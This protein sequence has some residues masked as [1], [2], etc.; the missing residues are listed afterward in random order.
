MGAACSKNKSKKGQKSQQ[1]NNPNDTNKNQ[2]VMRPANTEHLANTNEIQKLPDTNPKLNEPN[3]NIHFACSPHMVA[4]ELSQQTPVQPNRDPKKQG[5]NSNQL[6]SHQ[7]TVDNS[8]YIIKSVLL[9]GR[10]I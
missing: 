9:E 5:S 1:S 6:E 3:Q 2:P 8:K 10:E 7:L 4:E